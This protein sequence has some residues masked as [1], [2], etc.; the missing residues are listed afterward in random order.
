MEKAKRNGDVGLENIKISK[1]IYAN[2]DYILS[3]TRSEYDEKW[4]LN[5]AVEAAKHSKCKSQRG[6]VIWH[7]PSGSRTIGWNAPPLPFVC[8]G[9]DA[10][11]AQCSKTAVHAEQAA[12]LS[13][14]HFPIPM[15]QCEMLHVKIVNGLAVT[16]EK[17]SCWAC[18]KLILQSGLKSMWLYQK[19][20]LVEYSA[21][22]FHEQTLK[23]C[24]LL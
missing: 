24:D 2:S 23:N 10:C 22:E 16:S 7:R 9:S 15:N 18:S 5:E 3:I 21:L 6:V 4:A 20:G 13:A 19:E 17:P 12:L 1:E 11:K 14:L 8:D